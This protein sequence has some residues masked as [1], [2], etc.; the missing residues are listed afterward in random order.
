MHSW[1]SP[2]SIDTYEVEMDLL[3]AVVCDRLQLARTSGLLSKLTGPLGR[4]KAVATAKLRAADLL[5]FR[6]STE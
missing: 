3:E 5:T 4:S 1:T 2:A 6:A